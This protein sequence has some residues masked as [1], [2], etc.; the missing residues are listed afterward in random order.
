MTRQWVKRDP[1][2]EKAAIADAIEGLL[3]EVTPESQPP[4]VSDLATEA[5][6]RRDYLYDHKD[7]LAEFKAGIAKRSGK[8]TRLIALEKEVVEQRERIGALRNESAEKDEEI[9]VLRL[10]L[11]ETSL[12]LD[13]AQARLRKRSEHPEGRRRSLSAVPTSDD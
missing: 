2:T 13:D 9:R 10:L 7:L 11:A 12:A 5:G 8:S 6:L 3:S 1:D 4:S